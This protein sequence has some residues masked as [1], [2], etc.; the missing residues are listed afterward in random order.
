MNILPNRGA[1]PQRMPTSP[2]PGRQAAGLSTLGHA[3]PRRPRV[4][5]PD[6]TPSPAPASLTTAV[7]LGDRVLA[8]CGL[9]C[10]SPTSRRRRAAFLVPTDRSCLL[11]TGVHSSPLPISERGC[12]S[13]GLQVSV[14]SV[15]SSLKIHD[16]QALSPVLWVPLH[17]TA[18]SLAH[19]LPQASIPCLRAGSAC[20]LP[21]LAW[22]QPWKA[23]LHLGLHFPALLGG[24][25]TAPPSAWLEHKHTCTHASCMH[26]CAHMLTHARTPTRP[27]TCA[28]MQTP[29]TCTHTCITHPHAHTCTQA[30]M[31]TRM[32]AHVC[33]T[34]VHIHARTHT[35]LSFVARLHAQLLSSHPPSAQGSGKAR[36]TAS[37]GQFLHNTRGVWRRQNTFPQN[38]TSVLSR[39]DFSI[40][41]G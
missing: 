4:Q 6:C 12:S 18:L 23:Q 19:S 16:P 31:H 29:C 21:L 28:H 38:M 24:P 33:N 3:C 9:V 32:H 7:L 34:H 15:Y 13:L 35:L 14:H 36:K 30:R 22:P 17:A 26:T 2:S 41:T 1:A 20:S 25:P 10:S 8:H 39:A 11:W 37:S 40:S 27:H 5:G